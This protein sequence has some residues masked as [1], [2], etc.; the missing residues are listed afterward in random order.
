MWKKSRIEGEKL[1]EDEF[2]EK[3]KTDEIRKLEE[4]AENIE[5]IV[6]KY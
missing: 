4:K 2:E 3:T 5:D 6:I 1:L